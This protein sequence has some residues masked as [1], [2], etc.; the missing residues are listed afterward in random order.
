[1]QKQAVHFQQDKCIV[2]ACGSFAI[3]TSDAAASEVFYALRLPRRRKRNSEKSGKI[4]SF[5]H[6]KGL[7]F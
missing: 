7:T 2:S 3:K 5:S 4:P 6:K 1:M